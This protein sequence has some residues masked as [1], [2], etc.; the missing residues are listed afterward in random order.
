VT[1]ILVANNVRDI[2]TDR[3]A[4]KRTLAVR[5]GRSRTRVLFAELVYGAFFLMW[6]RRANLTPRHLLA[7]RPP[8]R[9]PGVNGG[10]ARGP[11]LIGAKA[12][13]RVHFAVGVL[14]AWGWQCEPSHIISSVIS[15]K[16]GLADD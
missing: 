16:P 11:A 7:L 2:D 1:A 6:L 5:L 4:G 14:L 9:D 10:D 13:A 3:T 8:R 12:T 15:Q